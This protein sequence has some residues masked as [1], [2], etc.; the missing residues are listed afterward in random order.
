MNPL[1]MNTNNNL[2]IPNMS[3][4]EIASKFASKQVKNKNE[5]ENYIVID[6]RDRNTNLYPNIADYRIDLEQKYKKSSKIELVFALSLI[7]I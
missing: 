4:D 7:H 2:I 5:N 3:N 1:L 6:S